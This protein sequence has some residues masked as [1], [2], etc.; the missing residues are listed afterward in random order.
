[1]KRVIKLLALVLVEI[2]LL[3]LIFSTVWICIV[4]P[5]AVNP[6]CEYIIICAAVIGFKQVGM[7]IGGILVGKY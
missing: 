6:L 2:V 1:M 3:L 5:G 7:L 4:C